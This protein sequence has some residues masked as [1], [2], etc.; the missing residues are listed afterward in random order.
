MFQKKSG[1]NGHKLTIF[2]AF[3]FRNIVK[4]RPNNE[5]IIII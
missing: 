5:I 4:E 2:L 1:Y 3:K